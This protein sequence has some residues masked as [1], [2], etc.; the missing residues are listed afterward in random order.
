MKHNLC[1]DFD[2]FRKDVL[3]R[4]EKGGKRDDKQISERASERA[5]SQTNKQTNKQMNEQECKQTGKRI[6]IQSSWL[7]L[8]F[9]TT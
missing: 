6:K 1:F 8:R 3:K 4:W 5:S 7:L 2:Q 9:T